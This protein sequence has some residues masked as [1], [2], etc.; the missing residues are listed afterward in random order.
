MLKNETAH[1]IKERAEQR[2][3]LNK[4]KRCMDGFR[5]L[6]LNF[7]KSGSPSSRQTGVSTQTSLAD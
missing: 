2:R 4:E 6:N 5:V 3:V 1:D 7:L